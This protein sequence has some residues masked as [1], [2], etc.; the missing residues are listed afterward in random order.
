MRFFNNNQRALINNHVLIHMTRV[1]TM[2]MENDMHRPIEPVVPPPNLVLSLYTVS[3]W[4]HK[5]SAVK[6][7]F[8]VS[9]TAWLTG[10]EPQA[11]RP[12]EPVW[13]GLQSHAG[14]LRK[15]NARIILEHRF[16]G[17]LR[18]VYFSSGLLCYH[19]GNLAINR[20]EFKIF[21]HGDSFFRT[22]M[23]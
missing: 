7:G 11:E 17:I 10:A 16:Q 2:N 13:G 9:P 5:K 19:W 20:Y 22:H 6:S 8:F 23:F 12:E 18:N 4:G 14:R 21:R 15:V 3:P 1:R